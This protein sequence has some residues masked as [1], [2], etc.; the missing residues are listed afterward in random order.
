MDLSEWINEIEI[1]FK[2]DYG[3]RC[4]TDQSHGFYFDIING[5]IT[6][7]DDIVLTDNDNLLSGLLSD[8]KHG[9]N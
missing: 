1:T 7:M 5:K 2:T 8:L 9:E 6:T 3:Y 4:Y